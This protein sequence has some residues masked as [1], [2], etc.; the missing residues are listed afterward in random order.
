MSQAPLH[1]KLAALV[2]VGAA[3]SSIRDPDDLL[4]QILQEAMDFSGA[5]GATLYLKR[6]DFLDFHIALNKSLERRL[7]KGGMSILYEKF[8]IPIST[9][10]MAGYCA[11]SGK[12]LNMPD[13]QD[14]PAG[15]QFRHNRDFDEKAG[16]DTHSVLT[17]P[18]QDRMGQCVGVI[19]L[20]NAMDEGKIIPFDSDTEML[21]QAFSSQ[22]GVS[23]VNAQL[24]EELSKAHQETLFR[25][26]TA[27]EY[28]DKETSNHIKRMSHYSRIIAKEYGLPKDDVM[29]IYASSPMHD[30]GK[31]GIPDH[32]LQKPGL[33]DPEERALMETHAIIGAHIL[34]DSNVAVV[35]QAAVVALTHH[36]KFDGTG[37]PRKLK[38]RNIPLVGRIC[39]LADVFDALS[40]K[41]CYKEPW[42]EDKVMT[43]L[44]T[45]KGKHFDP[46]MVDCL[47]KCMTE[48][49]DIQVR[50]M[51]TDEDFDKFRN[52]RLLKVPTLNDA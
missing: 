17:V 20:V 32:I 24:D 6:G 33:L 4:E 35:R 52:I 44:Q 13:M 5:D 29:S 23:I 36:E 27:A 31:I 51:D 7:G 48:V 39:A 9:N 16:Y 22:A 14:L 41:R 1:E 26:S 34:K 45:Q 38:G 49:R 28:R 18:M 8:S 3:I 43:F 47:L 21:M 50:H 11:L 37:Y 10:S 46:E 40:S 15:T 19:Q 12:P 2:R 42:S 30:V 25:L